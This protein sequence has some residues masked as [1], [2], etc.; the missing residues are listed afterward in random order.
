MQVHSGT[1]YQRNNTAQTVS[2][3]VPAL[4]LALALL[5]INT[6]EGAQT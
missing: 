3:R 1:R 6:M 2:A 5:L 4:D